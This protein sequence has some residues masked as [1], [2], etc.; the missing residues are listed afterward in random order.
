[1]L[2]DVQG[3]SKEFRGEK[4]ERTEAIGR[5]RVTDTK[6]AAFMDRLPRRVLSR[7]PAR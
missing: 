7:S 3:A 6:G 2:G 5:C 1:M 4:S